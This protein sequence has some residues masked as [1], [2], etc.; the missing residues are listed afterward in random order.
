MP[1]SESLDFSNPFASD[2]D[3]SYFLSQS[4]FLISQGF[5]TVR[6]A[7]HLQSHEGYLGLMKTCL[8]FAVLDF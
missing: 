8:Q 5:G 3:Q 2:Y 4:C 1:I 7:Y 6:E